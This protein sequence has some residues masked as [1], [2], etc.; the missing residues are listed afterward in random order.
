MKLLAVICPTRFPGK[1]VGA[2][3]C[4]TCS[5]KASCP[6]AVTSKGLGDVVADCLERVGIKPCKGCKKRQ[7]VLNTLGEAVKGLIQ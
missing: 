6:V 5:H 7:E 3:T 2:A 4:Q 1:A